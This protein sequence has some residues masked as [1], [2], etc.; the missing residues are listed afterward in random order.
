MKQAGG[1]D[2]KY[3][4]QVDGLVRNKRDNF[5]LFIHPARKP[6]EE[7]L[8]DHGQMQ[9]DLDAACDGGHCFV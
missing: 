2:W 9:F 7:A 4:K 5:E 1:Y 3:A 8:D 6:L